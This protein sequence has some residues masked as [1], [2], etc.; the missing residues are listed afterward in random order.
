MARFQGSGRIT[1]QAMVAATAQTLIQLEAPTNHRIALL[2]Y[3][4]GSTGVSNTQEPGRIDIL[5][6]STAGTATSLTL[7][8]DDDS[9]ADTLLTSGQHD[10]T[11]EPTPGEIMRSHT[12]HP[13][14]ALQIT[15]AYSRE[16]IVGGSDY[17]GL[18]GTFEDIQ[19]LDAFMVFEE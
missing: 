9:I 12:L 18:R 4:V 1:D 16:I 19:N 3:G 2:R 7:T 14:A 15:D 11:V 13:Q 17:I 8:K 5:R 10:F 6:Q